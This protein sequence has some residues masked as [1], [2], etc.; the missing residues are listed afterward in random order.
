[1]GDG[2]NT[3]RPVC[4]SL[5]NLEEVGESENHMFDG[6]M[7]KVSEETRWRG[8]QPDKTYEPEGGGGDDRL[9]AC[10]EVG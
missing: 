1:M 2:L 7:H 6:G 5:V 8:S 3:D 10:F 4:S 9:F